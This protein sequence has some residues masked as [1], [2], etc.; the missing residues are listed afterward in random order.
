MYL[1]ATFLGY[2]T[3]VC[4]T[5]PDRH[6]NQ[7]GVLNMAAPSHATMKIAT[8]SCPHVQVPYQMRSRTVA[9]SWN[10]ARCTRVLMEGRWQRASTKDQ[11]SVYHN[12]KQGDASP[13]YPA[14]RIY[15]YI[16]GVEM[17]AQTREKNL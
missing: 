8:V 13:M 10:D 14:T 2:L 12:Q 3:K 16:K 15:I 11:V 7:S 5:R 17:N 9:I 1:N 6:F 4:F